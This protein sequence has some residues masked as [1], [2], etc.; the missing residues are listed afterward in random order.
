MSDKIVFLEDFRP[1]RMPV[2]EPMVS[3]TR[4]VT[5]LPA[6]PFYDLTTGCE[7]AEQYMRLEYELVAN[8]RRQ[9]EIV[10]EMS[11]I[12]ERFVDMLEKE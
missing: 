8:N 9:A 10:Q 1:F 4:A 7:L 3:I 5:P 6:V 11:A 12:T 2:A